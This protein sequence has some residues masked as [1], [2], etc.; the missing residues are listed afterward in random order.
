MKLVILDRD[1]TINHDSDQYIKSP[2]E[3]KP[4]KGSLEAI[5]RLTQAGWHVVVATNQSG[6]GRGLFDM[7]TLNAIHDSMHRA[8]HQ[9]GGRIDA[10][11]FCPHADASNCECRKPKPGMLLE[12]AKRMNVGLEGVPMV[13]DSLRDLQ[14]ASAAGAKPVLVLTGKGKKTRDAGGLPAGTV[15]VADLAAFA[16]QL[17]P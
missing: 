15:V 4:I 9:A 14:A 17:V 16:A 11:F 5:A 3:W 7:A 12:I 13:G 10:V 6:I 2:A 8:V 1:G